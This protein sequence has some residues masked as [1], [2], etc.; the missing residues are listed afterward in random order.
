MKWY[1]YA[2]RPL[3]ANLVTYGYYTQSIALMHGVSVFA[4]AIGIGNDLK[5]VSILESTV[6][7][8]YY[9]LFG[10]N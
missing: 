1:S 9:G 2:I 8:V 5:Y 6:E 10:R 4:D 7:P 3:F